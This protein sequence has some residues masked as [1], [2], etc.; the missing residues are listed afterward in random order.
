MMINNINQVKL[1]Y[2]NCTLE[3]KLNFISNFEFLLPYER[4]ALLQ[5]KKHMS[6][7]EKRAYK[8]AV[9]KLKNKDSGGAVPPQPM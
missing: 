6:I 5:L 4:T 1:M 3:Q 8:K 7:E 9:E 2:I